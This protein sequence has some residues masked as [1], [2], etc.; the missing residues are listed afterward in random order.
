M[1]IEREI[2]R[3][4]MFFMIIFVGSMFEFVCVRTYVHVRVCEI[5]QCVCACTS[6]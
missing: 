3:S 6:L 1:Y 4:V 5:F 2:E